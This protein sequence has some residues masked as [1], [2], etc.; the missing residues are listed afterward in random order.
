M[1]V[2]Y[3]LKADCGIRHNHANKQNP[4]QFP[5]GGFYL[6]PGAARRFPSEIRYTAR[7]IRKRMTLPIFP[8]NDAGL[9]RQ[10]HRRKAQ[11]LHRDAVGN[12][13][14]LEHH[15]TGLHFANPTVDRAFTFT[16]PNLDRFGGHGDI[17]ENPDPDAAL[18]FHVTR[19][20]TT[21]G[22][23]LTGGHALGLGGLEAV[24]PEVQVRSTFG[25]AL[26]AALMLLAELC[27]LWLKHCSVLLSD[28]R[29]RHGA[30]DHLGAPGLC[31]H[32]PTGR[33][34]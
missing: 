4:R 33:A 12:A 27:T 6:R 5:D 11:G 28:G 3:G 29:R 23:D 16:H 17:R 30:R 19:H 9:D 22:F 21:G 13:V 2:E 8:N 7:V 32:G 14:D 31:D 18:T 34:P 15:A 25:E 26:D 10:F 24:G 20:G 1:N